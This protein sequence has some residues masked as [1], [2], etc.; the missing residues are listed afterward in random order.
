MARST[1]PKLAAADSQPPTGERRASAR[2]PCNQETFCQP[3][4]A[5]RGDDW[6]WPARIR[7]I[8]LRGVGLLL[9]RRF[10]RGTILVIELQ[11]TGKVCERM[12]IARV[13]HATPQESGDWIVGCEFINPLSDEDLKDMVG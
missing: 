10:E 6:R 12:M 5:R 4:A 11:G 1:F 8:S 2:L 9:S 13:I 7:D 3:I